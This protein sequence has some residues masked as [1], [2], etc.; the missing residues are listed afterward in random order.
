MKLFELDWPLFLERLKTWNAIAPAS[1][2]AY[3][4]L[5]SNA[6]TAADEFG[7]DLERLVTAK[8]LT[9]YTDG[10][11]V[12]LHDTAR[13]T[14]TALRAMARH[15]LTK[16]SASTLHAYVADHFSNAE[17]QSLI[18]GGTYYSHRALADQVP[19][20]QWLNN[21]LT[22]NAA[23]WIRRCFSGRRGTPDT[24]EIRAVQSLVRESMT[25]PEPVA[26][27]ELP[28]RA[29]SV[30]PKKLGRTVELAVRLLLL[31]PR[32]RDDDQTA[33]IGLWPGVADRLQRSKPSPPAAVEPGERFQLAFR[34]SDMT[35]L[36]VA[37]ASENVRVR[38]DDYHLF[39]R[40]AEQIYEELV[41]L[42][43]WLDS[44]AVF[45]VARRVEQAHSLLSQMKLV[46]TKGQAGRNLRLA[47]TSKTQQ[48]LA[49]TDRERI[50]QVIRHWNL[51]ESPPMPGY[52]YGGYGTSDIRRELGQSAGRVFAETSGENF[53]DWNDFLAYHAASENPLVELVGTERGR[54]FEVGLWWS[55]PTDEQIEHLWSSLLETYLRNYLVPLG[56]VELGMAEGSLCFRLTDVGR[57]LL[58]LADDFSYDVSETTTEGEIVVQPNFEIVFLSPSPLAEATLARYAERLKKARGHQGVGALFKI[59]KDSI[60]AA[61]ATGLTSEQALTTLAG[62][63]SKDV[64]ANVQREIRGWFDQCRTITLRRAVLI[65]CPDEDTAA[66]VVS[67]GG[68]KA[69][70]ITNTIVELQNADFK[71][72]LIKKLKTMGVF[73]R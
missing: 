54:A 39:Q 32:L 63:S 45:S 73:V 16:A 36:L 18:P 21:I 52:Y 58:G 67:A 7:G 37:A 51:A 57:C 55:T 11:R 8:L 23:D 22:E 24:G 62:I 68:R 61:A 72:A 1:R 64:P 60:L 30:P 17:R 20:V 53:A 29:D 56:G 35:T 28:Q 43:S 3:L 10:K 47:T 40:A 50:Q 31:F 6:S 42:P 4:R 70:P 34:V 46:G 65:Y 38:A 19:S 5:R 12:R 2:S 69:S 25:W 27:D 14:A 59:T 13:A 66:R 49:A 9:R 41:P 71:P 48:W 44:M 33:V 15:P 26:F